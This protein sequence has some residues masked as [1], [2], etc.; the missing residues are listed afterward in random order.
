MLQTPV[1]LYTT[2]GMP[3]G[4]FAAINMYRVTPTAQVINGTAYSVAIAPAS[5]ALAAGAAS[6]GVFLAEKLSLNTAGNLVKRTDAIGTDSDKSLVRKDPTLTVTLQC[7]SVGTPTLM[8]GDCF[9]AHIGN[10]AAS[11]S[12]VPA[13]IALSRWFI[14]AN[15]INYDPN[16]PTKFS[17][18]F[19][20]DRQNSAATLAE[21]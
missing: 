20:L 8:P 5:G 3:I 19:E 11:T 7:A 14:T 15:G 1:I 10:T 9:E 18:T 13:S 4:A 16:D 21:F 17:V 6:L 12:A 2:A